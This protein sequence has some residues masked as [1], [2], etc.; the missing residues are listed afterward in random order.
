[1]LIA[2]CLTEKLIILTICTAHIYT[3]KQHEA[4]TEFTHV[5]MTFYAHSAAAAATTLIGLADEIKLD[6]TSFFLGEG[7]MAR[8]FYYWDLENGSQSIICCYCY[9]WGNP[10]LYGI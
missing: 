3:H 10:G 4:G 9:C 5:L 2:K 7:S 8:S 1:M 6:R